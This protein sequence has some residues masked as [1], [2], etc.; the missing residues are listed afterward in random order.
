MEYLRV[1]PPT[2]LVVSGLLVSLDRSRTIVGGL[3]L[4]ASW[5]NWREIALRGVWG[6]LG[7]LEEVVGMAIARE[8]LFWDDE[9]PKALLISS[10]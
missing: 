8:V 9:G 5:A 2:K 7:D 10:T 1:V 4:I 6:T 3:V